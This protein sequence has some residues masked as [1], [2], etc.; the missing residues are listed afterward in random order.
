[1]DYFYGDDEIDPSHLYWNESTTKS[2]EHE[3]WNVKCKSI[4]I[5]NHVQFI[6]FHSFYQIR[7]F[8]DAA[9]IVNEYHW[10]PT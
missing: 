6:N 1:M 4:I 5:G 7:G 9:R 3:W 8:L 10:P 2:P